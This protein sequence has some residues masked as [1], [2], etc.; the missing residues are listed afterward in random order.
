MLFRKN[1]L[2]S[3]TR[4][5]NPGDEFILHGII[6]LFKYILDDFNPVIFNRNPEIKHPEGCEFNLQLK[7]PSF[8]TKFIRSGNYDNS[9]KK[10][11]IKD[12]FI[13]LVVFAG[14][15]EWAGKKMKVLYRFIRKH[16]LSTIYLGI[17]AGSKDFTFE[18]ID[19]EYKRIINKS[20][21]ITVRDS[22]TEKALKFLAPVYLP[23]PA[24]LAVPDEREKEVK[25]VKKVGLIYMADT[26]VRSNSLSEDMYYFLLSFYEIIISK[27][28]DNIKFEFVC[29]YVNELAFFERDF[30]ERVCHYSYE[31][32]DYI[33]IYSK[34]DL[35][36][37]PR[38]HGIGLAAS[39]GIPGINIQHDARACTCSAFMSEII[40]ASAGIGKAIEIFDN[41]LIRVR[42]DNLS[43]KILFRK[44]EVFNEYIELLKPILIDYFK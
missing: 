11:L 2:F 35:V 24:F 19:A 29:H 36:V 7:L 1:I 20:L 15:P 26:G 34:F 13:D 8:N 28:S 12:D 40:D 3:T 21:L 22:I 16:S 25:A 4:Q 32:K 14:T 5:W 41:M 38:V 23:C 6:R 18:D 43:S 42:N 17:G 39:L 27:F 10:K 37:G 33:D 30:P 44:R 31:S 9:F